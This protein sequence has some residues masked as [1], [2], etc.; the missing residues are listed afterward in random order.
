MAI[1]F[2]AAFNSGAVFVVELSL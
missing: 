1:A 2:D